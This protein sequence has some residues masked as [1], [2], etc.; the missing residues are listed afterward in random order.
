VAYRGAIPIEKATRK[1]EL[2][3]VAGWIGPGMHFVQYPLRRGQLYNQVA[4]FR[5]GRYAAG[6]EDWGT[7]E[8]LDAAFAPACDHIREALPT[9]CRDQRWPM[10]DREPIDHWIA[11]R[12]VL[13]GDAAHPMLQYLAQGACQAMEDAVA[14][15]DA[16]DRHGADWAAG[17][18][19]YQDERLPR[20]RRVQ[21]TA[22]VWG[23]MWHVDGVSRTMRN[24][25]FRKR[26][27]DDHRHV[28]WLYG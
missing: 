21:Q 16:L 10:Y 27:P 1:A 6:H 8:E 25:L 13:L 18:A 26:R 15:T 23:D 9:L 20:T 11:G 3:E 14:L 7:T 28:E 4:V 19:A 24:E 5:S 12:A 17:L 22:R 2:T